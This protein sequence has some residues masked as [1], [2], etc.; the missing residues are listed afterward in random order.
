MLTVGSLGTTVAGAGVNITTDL[1]NRSETKDYIKKID[2]LVSGLQGHFNELEDILAMYTTAVER[3]MKIHG[4]DENTAA[5]F[6]NQIKEKFPRITKI[7][8]MFSEGAAAFKAAVD[9]SKTIR[10]MKSIGT[11]TKT[12]TGGTAFTITKSLSQLTEVEKIAIGKYAPIAFGRVS[13]IGKVFKGALIAVNVGFAV[14]D[15]ISLVKDWKSKHPAVE[16]ID[17]ALGKLKVIENQTTKDL[18]MIERIG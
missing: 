16:T 1:I 2:D 14:W 15:I 12:A 9:L 3:I 6:I 10:T 18:A 11:F 4:L 5:Y 13:V 7:T 17:D 8:I